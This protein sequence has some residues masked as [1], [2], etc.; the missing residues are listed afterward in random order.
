MDSGTRRVEPVLHTAEEPS[1][2]GFDPAWPVGVAPAPVLGRAR[3]APSERLLAVVAMLVVVVVGSVGVFAFTRGKSFPTNWDDGV[4]PI[5]SRVE[6]LRG[7]TF[8]HSVKVNYLP[9][10][11][12]EQRFAVNESQ[13]IKERKQIDQAGALLRSTGLLGPGVDLADAVSTTTAADTLAL[14]DP[15]TK[16]IYV[17][18]T[19]PL[20]IETRVTLAHELTHV[21]QDQ[22]FDLTKL[23]KR[24]LASKSGSSDALRALIEG[25]ATR[26]QERY[27]AEQ[28]PAAQR[29][30]RELS[31]RTGTEARRRTAHIPAVVE[32]LF[33]A[34]YI[35]GPQVIRV[36]EA[37]DGDSAIDAALT[38]PTPS[39]RIYL[40]PTA[41]GDAATI[42]PVPALGAGESKVTTA[43]GNEDAFDNFTLYLIL[44]ARLGPSTAL[45]AADAYSA[46]SEVIYEVGDRTCLRA[47]IAGRNARA[48]SYLAAVLRRW[49]QTM[50]NAKI[51]DA[52]D[53]TVFE[54][55]DPGSQAEAPNDANIR[56]AISLAAGRDALT[57]AFA[58]QD[59]S[60]A[61]AACAARL[62]VR[63]PD[64]RKALLEGD[65][66][67]L[68]KPTQQTLRESIDAG[69]RCRA[70]SR[71]GI[72]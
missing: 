55:C 21:L 25:D 53:T 26:I 47:S 33:S 69:T 31:A 24:A 20:T 34:P 5:A 4:E 41:V 38:G 42:P 43:L 62:L 9:A 67:I 30:Y 56:E 6:A 3:R 49:T 35:F 29:A 71:A 46:G 44:A 10:P 7:L 50:P 23:Q 11:A 13:L 32:T 72:P 64:F 57:A 8:K 51:D 63:Q 17:R 14:Y 28:S 61:F 1:A 66:D 36:L 48:D 65:A 2:V 58:K 54:S 40:D 19:G 27:L 12:F 68:R 60:S 16:Q 22:N 39:T 59:V 18:G 45:R 52:A 15:G 70:N 37:T